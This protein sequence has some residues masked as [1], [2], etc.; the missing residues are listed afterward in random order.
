MHEIQPMTASPAMIDLITRNDIVVEATP[1]Q[2]WPHIVEVSAW[3]KGAK[4]LKIAGSAGQVGERFEAVMGDDPG[5][6]IFYV[7]NVEV[8]PQRCR[9]IRLNAPD[10][11]LL[12]Y[13]TW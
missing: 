1:A 6:V 4:L 11:K 13:A 7:E 10:G 5:E 3:K 12:G 9:T 8:I 2:I